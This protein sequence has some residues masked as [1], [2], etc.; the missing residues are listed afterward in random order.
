MISVVAVCAARSGAATA[1]AASDLDV[2]LR[3]TDVGEAAGVA[4]AADVAVLDM[5]TPGIDA[6]GAIELLAAAPVLSV[7]GSAEHAA[8]LA[9]V[10]AGAAGYLVGPVGMLRL[11]DAIRRVVAGEPVYSPGL[12]ELVLTEHGRAETAVERLTER[13]AEVLR[14]VVEGLTGKQIAAQLVLSPRTVENHV[15]NTLRKLGLPNRAA[16]VRYAIE[17][18][19]A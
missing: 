17:H 5:A 13:E 3:T 19:L 14:L 1:L 2:V 18:G 11:A 6:L 15:Q 4:V 10:R 9:A 8:V 12:A 7:A 16:L